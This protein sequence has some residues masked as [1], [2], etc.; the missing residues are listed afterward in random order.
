MEQVKITK[1]NGLTVTRKKTD[2]TAT[3]E[4]KYTTILEKGDIKVEITSSNEMDL[5][6]NDQID[7]PIVKLNKNLSEFNK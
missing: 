6:Y 7:L 2:Q 1:L 4:I 3:D 5:S